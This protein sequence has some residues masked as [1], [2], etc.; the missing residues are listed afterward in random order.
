MLKARLL[1]EID[2]AQDSLRFYFLKVDTPTQHYG[3]NKPV[4]REEPL[5]GGRISDCC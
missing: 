2:E 5:K 3:T 4:D 1:R